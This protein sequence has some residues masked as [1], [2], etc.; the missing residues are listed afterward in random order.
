MGPAKE[1]FD[2]EYFAGI[3]R[4]YGSNG[5]SRCADHRHPRHNGKHARDHRNGNPDWVYFHGYSWRGRN[6]GNSRSH[7]DY[8]ISYADQSV[9]DSDHPECDWDHHDSQPEHNNNSESVHNHHSQSNWNN[10][11]GQ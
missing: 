2:E 4:T 7:P 8:S 1:Q 6:L 11:S 5:C 10:H 3:I 9:I